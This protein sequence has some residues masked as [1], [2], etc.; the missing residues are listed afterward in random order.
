MTKDFRDVAQCDR[1]F[2]DT[3]LDVLRQELQTKYT[4]LEKRHKETALQLNAVKMMSDKNKTE[5]KLKTQR[6]NEVEKTLSGTED[7]LKVVEV[8]GKL[9]S[10]GCRRKFFD[11]F[12]FSNYSSAARKL[13]QKC[14]SFRAK[15]RKTFDPSKVGRYTK[16]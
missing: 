10:E 11:S 15:S 8:K 7:R 4:A 6:L 3:M 2:R 12:S 1:V 9:H 13:E 16:T 14:S 5:I